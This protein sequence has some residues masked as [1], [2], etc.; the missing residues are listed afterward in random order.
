[1][2]L[3]RCIWSCLAHSPGAAS[4]QYEQCV[5]ARCTDALLYG[6]QWTS[7]IASDGV[8]RFATTQAEQGMAF[9]YFCTPTLSY[10][11][12]ADV[13]VPAAAYRF[14]IGQT[15]YVVTLQGAP[16]QLTLTV[17]HDHVF[18]QAVRRGGAWLPSGARY[19]G[20]FDPTRKV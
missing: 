1:M 14:L 8:H 13:P 11:V 2:V 15:D 3:Q 6:H 4:P 9:T 12:L 5:T 16:G 18:T 17:P 20:S 10:F 7:G 19:S